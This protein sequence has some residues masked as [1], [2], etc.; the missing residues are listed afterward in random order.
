[1]E[2]SGSPARRVQ[3]AIDA[4]QSQERTDKHTVNIPAITAAY[5][6]ELADIKAQRLALEAW[7]SSLALEALK[8]YL[9][10]EIVALK[11]R[12]NAELRRL[13]A[14]AAAAAAARR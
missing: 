8:T 4:A 5:K 1:M 13:E 14:A 7:P 3:A 2:P 6:Q 10:T 11:S 12:L 9:Q